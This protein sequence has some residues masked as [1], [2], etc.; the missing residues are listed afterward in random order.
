MP[1][2]L[3]TQVFTAELTPMSL[4]C[5]EKFGGQSGDYGRLSG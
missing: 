1:H 4:L 5:A 2:L 3:E